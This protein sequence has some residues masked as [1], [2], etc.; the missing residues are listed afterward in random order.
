MP[1][2]W[3]E[4]EHRANALGSAERPTSVTIRTLER[5]SRSADRRLA[6]VAA[7]ALLVA[8]FAGAVAVGTGLVRVPVIVPAPAESPSLGPS[9][10]VSP[11]SGPSVDPTASPSITAEPSDPASGVRSPWIVFRRGGDPDAI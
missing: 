2:L 8:L 7:V 11:S 4:V 5:P 10:D 3:P 9:A 1:E 6:V